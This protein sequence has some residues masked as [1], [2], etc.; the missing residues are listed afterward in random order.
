MIDIP[1]WWDGNVESLKATVY[2]IRP[3]IGPMKP[4]KDTASPIRKENPKD[5][6]LSSSSSS[7]QGIVMG[8]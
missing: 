4:T 3:D 2:Q 8:R 1:Y 6:L 7:G 5:P